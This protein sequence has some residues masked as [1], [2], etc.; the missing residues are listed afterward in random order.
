MSPFDEVGDGVFR[1]RYEFLDLNIGVIVGEDEVMVVDSRCSHIEADEL[2]VEI[3]GLT[4]LPIRHLVNTHFH[5][6][7]VWGNARFE[8]STIWGHERTRSE[9]VERG[10]LARERALERLPADRRREVREVVLTPPGSTM[11][12]LRD[13]TVGGRL[14]QLRYHGRAHTDSD[15]IVHVPDS[16]V[17]F[18]GDVIEEGAPPSFGDSYPLEWPLT[19]AVILPTL[20]PTI[21]PGHGDVVDPAFVEAQRNELESIAE[22][23]RSVA[24]GSDPDAALAVMP[25]ADEA[26][27]V[28]T[29]RGVAQLTGASPN[30]WP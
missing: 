3:A 25:Y 8:H 30:L 23:I 22:G 19:L 20:H 21:V 27:Q 16:G 29:R 2:L 28:A 4:D 17:S 14:V 18:M 11:V 1:R 9:I 26:C 7:H 13:V 10:E 12:G 24:A 15:V 5:W 6:D